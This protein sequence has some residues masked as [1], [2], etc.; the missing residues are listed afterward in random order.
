MQLQH[1]KSLQKSVAIY[2]EEVQLFRSIKANI[3]ITANEGPYVTFHLLICSECIFLACLCYKVVVVMFIRVFM[4]IILNILSKIRIFLL[5]FCHR[6]NNL[7]TGVIKTMK[8]I[9]FFRELCSII[10]DFPITQRLEIWYVHN[11]PT[12]VYP[13]KISR[14]CHIL[15][16]SHV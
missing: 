7:S 9:T 11:S 4:T 14:K 6:C 5:S 8:R 1:I 12:L 10:S 13:C 16:R 2:P 15:C 3:L